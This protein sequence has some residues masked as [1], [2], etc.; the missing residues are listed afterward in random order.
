[1]HVEE[2]CLYRFCW[3]ITSASRFQKSYNQIVKGTEI[4]NAKVVTWRPWTRT[5]RG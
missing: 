2:K 4:D 1:L 3:S 5:S